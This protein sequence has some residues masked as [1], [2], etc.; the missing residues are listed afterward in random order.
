MDCT[1][2]NGRVDIIQPNTKALFAMADK[3]DINQCTAYNNA[4]EGNWYNTELSNIYFSKNNL[5]ALQIGIKQGVFNKSSG[6][7]RVG[8][9]SCDELKT[10]MRSVFLQYAQNK[11]DNIIEQVQK[12]NG[13]VL[14]YAVKQVYGEA[15][16]YVKYRYDASTLVTP[17]DRPIMSKTNDKQLLLKNFF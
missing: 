2:T 11:P 3:I 7:Y 9:Q 4:M 15:K 16:S 13:I 6:A 17:I 12:L 14:E 1:K 10:I 5:D 8:D